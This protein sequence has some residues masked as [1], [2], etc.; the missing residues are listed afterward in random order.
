VILDLEA[1]ISQEKFKASLVL[2]TANSA[3][4]AYGEESKWFSAENQVNH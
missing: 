4:D 2:S 1:K 3:D